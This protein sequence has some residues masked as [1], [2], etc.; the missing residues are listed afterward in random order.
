MSRIAVSGHDVLGLRAD[1]P[2]PLTLE[3]TNTWIVSRDPAW[4]IDPGP[5]LTEH[6]ERVLAELEARGGLGAILL[7]HDHGDHSAAV[8]ALRT[9]FAAAPLAAG[10]GEAEIHLADGIQVGPLRAFAAPGHAA[11]HF[12][13]LADESTLAFTGDAVLGA[14]SVFIAPEPGALA[15]YLAALEAL[16]REPLELICPGHGP[17]IDRPQAK[18]AE[19]LEHRRERER[20]LLD[21]LAAGGRTTEELLDHAWSEA[22]RELRPAAALTLAAHLDK[23]AGEGRLPEGVERTSGWDPQALTG[24]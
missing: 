1:N 4:L 14:G 22:P 17:L 13:F 10:R 18:L 20:R 6:V 2:G 5:D 11:D 23:L 7:T 9:R 8:P 15:R 21:A 12:V 19:Y 3:G 24:L 16:A